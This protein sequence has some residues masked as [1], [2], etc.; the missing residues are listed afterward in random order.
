[1]EVILFASR[2]LIVTLKKLK[3][4]MGHTLIAYPKFSLPQPKGCTR[5]T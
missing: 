4:L 1:M 5:A 2:G 3:I